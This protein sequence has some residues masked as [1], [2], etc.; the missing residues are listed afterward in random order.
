MKRYLAIVLSVLLLM[1]SAP[2]VSASG[3]YNDDE[4]NWGEYACT[5]STT[6]SVAAVESTCTTPGCGAYERCVACGLVVAGSDAR[7]PLADHTYDNACDADCN[8]C[9]EVRET[10]HNY[11]DTEIVPDCEN[12]GYIIHTCTV[13]G[14]SYVD[15]RVDALGHDYK[16]TEDVAP[17]CIADGKKVYVCSSC[18]DSYTETLPATGKHT[19][20]YGCDEDCNVCGYIREDAHDYIFMGTMEPTCGEDGADGYKCWDCGKIKYV[21]IPATGNHT[22][23]GVCDTDCNKCGLVREPVEPHNYILTDKVDPTC[24]TDG[25]RTY[26]CSGCGDSYTDIDTAP[27]HEYD[28]VVTAPDC[29][30]GGYT[31]HTCSVCGDSYVSDA[32]SAIGHDYVPLSAEPPTCT[33]DGFERFYCVNCGDSYMETIQAEGHKYDAVVTA[34]D[35]ENGGYTTHTCS[36]CGDSYVSDRTEALGHSS[37]VVEG[38]AATCEEDGL[39]DGEQCSVCGKILAAQV[40]I[41]AS[42]HSY[43]DDLDT[44]CNTCGAV[45]EVVIPGDAN[46]DGKVNNKDLALLQQYLADWDV[47]IDTHVADVN[48]DGKVNN[49]DLALLQQ[50]LADW[51]VVLK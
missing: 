42:G 44:D 38:Y 24:V 6:K 37:V 4:F 7:L 9:G 16:L 23:S 47:A 20:E 43:D 2:M 14:D 13:C 18:G 35:C 25:T 3:S 49:K 40:A 19:Y 8:V 30:N 41:P 5:H 22:Y 39:T 32:V 17:T 31:T 36:V 27:G 1:T 11:Q 50:Y 15:N 46:G 26:T 51:D 12:S 48:D 45:R 10:A 33:E 29:E 34:P 21:I 28:I